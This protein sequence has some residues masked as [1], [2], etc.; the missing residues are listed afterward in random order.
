MDNLSEGPSAY[1]DGHTNVVEIDVHCDVAYITIVYPELAYDR[2]TC[3]LVEV[4]AQRTKVHGWL[5]QVHS[6]NLPTEIIRKVVPTVVAA[7]TMFT[8]STKS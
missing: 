4:M 7:H 5:K 3:K 2:N 8:M 1:L 6:R